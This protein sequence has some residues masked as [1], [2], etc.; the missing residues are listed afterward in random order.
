MWF[1]LFP[2]F[3]SAGFVVVVKYINEIYLVQYAN[4]AFF[5]KE[6]RSWKENEWT[7]EQKAIDLKGIAKK[8]NNNGW[9]FGQLVK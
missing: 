1:K 8:S 9:R 3:I 4:V 2:F 5:M 6:R 7:N